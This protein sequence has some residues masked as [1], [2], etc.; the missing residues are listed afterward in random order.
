MPSSWL[1]TWQR[2]L[3]GL[4]DGLLALL[5]TSMTLLAAAQIVLRN[6]FD[7]GIS[8]S[9]PLLRLGVLWLTLL[10]AMAAAREDRHIRIEICQRLLNPLWQRRLAAVGHSCAALIGLVLAWA[11]GQLVFIEWQTGS[12]TGTGI[13][14]WLA[15]SI[16]PV[17]FA[18]MALR[19][20]LMALSLLRPAP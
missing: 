16:I 9:E 5:L 1:E 6:G 17:G 10:G 12:L 4:E 8:I 13:P 20:A 18:V 3:R 14:S 2:R 19:S 15:A 7:S 11:G